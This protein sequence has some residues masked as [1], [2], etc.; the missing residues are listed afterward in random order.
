ML[1]ISQKFLKVK[2]EFNDEIGT[3]LEDQ[4]QVEGLGQDQVCQ[5]SAQLVEGKNVFLLQ[6]LLVQS[7]ELMQV[8]E[9]LPVVRVADCDW[10]LALVHVADGLAQS[11]NWIFKRFSFVLFGEQ[12]VLDAIE[13]PFQVLFSRELIIA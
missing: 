2:W 7:D 13:V 10:G 1:F 4:V 5:Q 9:G 8:H 12:F 6:P 11:K 3:S